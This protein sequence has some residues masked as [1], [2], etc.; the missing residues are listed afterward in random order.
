M[1][2]AFP[3]SV[4]LVNPL[5][6]FGIDAYAHEL[7]RGLA[8]NHVRVDVF[9]AEMSRLSVHVTHPNYRRFRVLGSRL[10]SVL[11]DSGLRGDS[12][13]G[14]LPAPL[15]VGS[16]APIPLWRAWARKYYLGWELAFYLRRARYDVVWT[17]WPDLGP[18]AS[19]W[20]AA[21]WL[22][23]PI[24][25]SVHNILPHERTPGDMAMCERVYRTARLL[26]VHSA[27]VREELSAL[28][29]AYASKVVTMAH[30]T[31]TLY[32]RQFAARA[33]VRTALNIPGHAVVL[34][35]CGLI[36][37]YKNVDACIKALAEIEREDVILVIAG[38]EP[39]AP[40][41]DP[42]AQTRA[43]VAQ[44]GIGDR[45]R[46]QPGSMNENA[47]AEMF[48]AADVLMLPYL[49]SYGSGLLML[50][51]TFGKYIVATRSGMEESA[52]QY[53]G[54][55]FLAGSSAQDVRKGI[56]AVLERVKAQPASSNRPPPG[57]D[58][59]SITEQCLK[60]IERAVP[61]R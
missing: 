38:F 36:R 2:R 49:K 23:I 54:M 59:T 21:R 8:E 11:T 1:N 61:H 56:E 5:G 16:R 58:W 20:T 22:R 37:P 31:Y 43:L 14:D 28:F 27:P 7:A 3:Q 9:V 33:S 26:F 57:F 18:Y 15:S 12:K 48:E 19:F 46:L 35:C 40:Q 34:L 39:G 4:A 52:S 17:Q 24:V 30:G 29:P 51:I 25:H 47:M 41:H 60:D 42:L 32:P 44:V 45:V 6:D 50:G 13:S 55:V 10:P 53:S